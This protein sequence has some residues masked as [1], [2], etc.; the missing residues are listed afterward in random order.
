METT[1]FLP[2]ISP[3]LCGRAPKPQARILA[4]KMQAIHS[5][6]LSE[7]AD[8][9][10]DSLPPSL[11]ESRLKKDGSRNRTYTCYA[12]FWG[13]L[14]QVLSPSTSRL[15]V[16]RQIQGKSVALGRKAPSSATAAYCNARKELDFE[17]LEK[18]NQAI[19]SRLSAAAPQSRLWLGRRVKILDGACISLADTRANQ[20][21]YPQPST[22]KDGCG[23]PAMKLVGSF[24]LETG[25]LEDYCEMPQKSHESRCLLQ[26]ME[27]FAK[28]D[29]ALTDRGFSSYLNIAT[30]EGKGCDAVMRAHQGRK[31]DMGK[32]QSLGEGDRLMTWSRPQ[33]PKGYDK[34]QWEALPESLDIRVVTFEVR[35]K[36]FRTRSITLVTTLTDPKAFPRQA[37]IDLYMKRWSVE[38]RIRDIK[39]TMGMEIL[40]CKS[41]EMVRKELL[42]FVIAHNL[43]RVLMLESLSHARADLERISFK[44]AVDTLRQF[45]PYIVAAKSKKA[46]RD[47]IDSMIRIIAEGIVPE[48]VDRSEP[49]AVKRRPKNYQLLTS[50][51]HEMKV[52]ERRRK[53]P[54]KQRA[55]PLS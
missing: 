46:M 17:G 27:L 14:S 48:R 35:Q 22:Q 49:R 1:S 32:G 16:V 25:G 42:M 11:L 13:F 3:K 50:P 54:P 5:S 39:T 9:F 37:L 30:L 2:G 6:G 20:G 19:L 52:S 7:L 10:K 24:S 40:R 15:E 36:G 28:G 51:R 47:V 41:P 23:F 12:T 8:L 53:T 45:R 31:I 43:I 4:D 18:I 34:D 26:L 21:E 44:A 29:V 33:R 38:L 55:T